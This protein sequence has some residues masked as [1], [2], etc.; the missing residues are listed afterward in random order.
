MSEEWVYGPEHAEREKSLLMNR[1]NDKFPQG[2]N[3]CIKLLD[4]CRKE[5]RSFRIRARKT[6]P[7][8]TWYYDMI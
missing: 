4:R 3:E 7:F 8:W 6:F 2:W 1:P 5:G